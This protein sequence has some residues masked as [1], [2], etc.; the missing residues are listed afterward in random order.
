ML[1]VI[2]LATCTV[3]LSTYIFIKSKDLR[4]WDGKFIYI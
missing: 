1:G 2:S 3:A 4:Y